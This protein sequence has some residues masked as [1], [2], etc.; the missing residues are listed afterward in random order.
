ML[1]NHMDSYGSRTLFFHRD[2]KA[3]LPYEFT[4]FAD[5]NEKVDLPYEFIGF[6]S[7]IVNER[8]VNQAQDKVKTNRRHAEHAKDTLGNRGS[9]DTAGNPAPGKT[10]GPRTPPDTRGHRRQGTPLLVRPRPRPSAHEELS[11]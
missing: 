3:D 10:Q 8:S 6:L 9:E 7:T 11:R 4:W 1:E 5:P 2:E